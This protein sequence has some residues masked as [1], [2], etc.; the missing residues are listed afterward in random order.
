MNGKNPNGSAQLKR[1]RLV[2]R[3]WHAFHFIDEG[4]SSLVRRRSSSQRQM[5]GT[6]SNGFLELE[7]LPAARYEQGV[8][9]QSGEGEAKVIVL[10][11]RG[12]QSEMMEF[13]WGDDIGWVGAILA[14]IGRHVCQDLPPRSECS[15]FGVP[16]NGNDC[17]DLPFV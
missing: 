17:T 2:T 15:C 13:V 12:S 14:C 10:V 1:S 3:I 5:T 6:Q 16:R 11:R 4:G 9:H 7:P 8:R